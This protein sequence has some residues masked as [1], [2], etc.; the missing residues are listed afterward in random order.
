MQSLPRKSAV[1]FKERSD[2]LDFLLEVSAVTSQTLDLDQLLGNVAEIVQRVLRYDL[3]AILLYNERRRDLRI[4]YGVGHREEVVR[5][6]AIAL[7]EGI[8]GT[9]AASR[10]PVLVGDVR[11]DPRYLHT[12][13]AV[14]T[15]LAVP[16]TARGKLVGVIDLQST[17]L[18]AYTDYDRALLRLVAARV[19]IAIDKARLYLRVER[20]NRTLKT[21]ANISREFSSILDL[22]DLLSKI[23]TTMR[24]LINYDA[25]SILAVDQEAKALRH[26]FSIRYDQRVNTD[27]VPFGKGITGAAAESREVVRV[28]DTSKDPRYIPSHPG[29]RSEVAVPLMAHDRVLGVM[30]LESESIGYF[31]DDHVRT[32]TLLA[33][34][35]ASSVENARLYQELATRERRMEEDLRAARELQSVLLP[36]AAPEIDGLEAAVRL[37]PAR[38]ISGDICDIFELRDNQTVIAFGD[39]SGKGAAAAL[40]G[41]LMNGLLRTLA[42]RHR[43]PAGLLRALNEA[44]I[45]RKVEARYVTLFVLLWDPATRQMVMANAGALPPMICR[46]SDILKVRAEG[47]PIGLLDSREYDEVAFQ[48]QPGDLV[49][50]YSDGITDHMDSAGREFGRGRLAQIL[51]GNCEKPAGDVVSAIFREI[52]AFSTTAFDDQT[53]FALKVR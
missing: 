45:A 20:Q 33:P 5:N 49:V 42:P 30:D 1:R 18:N 37:R 15:E 40:Y 35:V 21:L 11:G 36:D 44:L 38:E 7:G 3:F 39:V 31:T 43:R 6:L 51:R 53:V 12:L 24:G 28:A 23:S 13:D 27:N 22:N 50:L 29:I 16:M 47:V 10:E 52:D 4:R 14:R 8:T 48:A 41:G 19:G 34:Q 46:G 26:L 25:F 2:L 17:R 32:L 9:A